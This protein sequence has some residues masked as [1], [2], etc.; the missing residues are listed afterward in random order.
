[1][2]VA[3]GIWTTRRVYL[4]RNLL[5]LFSWKVDEVIVFGTDQER[6][7]SLVETSPLAIPFFDR[8]ERALPR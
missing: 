7:S 5:L 3:G 6:N 2:L 1:M 8:V 4:V